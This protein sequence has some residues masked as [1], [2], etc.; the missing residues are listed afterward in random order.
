MSTMS[1]M[2]AKRLVAAVLWFIAGWVVGSIFA[3]GLG[4]SWVIGPALALAVAWFIAVDPRRMIWVA[5]PTP[6]RTKT[7]TV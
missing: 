7:T 3:F 2:N 1:R 5:E 4:L 6:A